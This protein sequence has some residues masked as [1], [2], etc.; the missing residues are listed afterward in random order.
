MNR[1]DRLMA[2]VVHLQ[3]RRVVRAE[4]L[5]KHFE[6]SL[7]TVYRDL[8]A[9]GEA[10]IPIV[11]EPGVG[12]SLINGYHL[13]PV[14]FTAEEA[15]ALTLS[16]K[17][18]E[19]HTD[20]SWSRQMGS[21]LAK[22]RSI[23]PRERQDYLDRLDRSTMVFARGASTNPELAMETLI[24]IQR[25]IAERRVLAIDYKGKQRTEITRREVEPLGLVHYADTWHLIAHCRLRNDLREFRTDRI[26]KLEL[27]TERFF[28]HEDF[29]LK[30]HV[31]SCRE[32]HFE[33]ACVQFQPTAMER[34]RREWFCGA[35]EEE[36]GAHGIVVNLATCTSDW[37]A[38]WILSFGLDALVLSPDHLRDRV[39]EL[40][41][42][43]A[44]QY[45]SG[46]PQL[47]PPAL[48]VIATR[49]TRAPVAT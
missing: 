42:R 21:A 16:G 10:G 46:R 41:A 18:V 3:G 38:G 32:G 14:M 23:L 44:S 31:E 43:V 49:P 2:M 20:A 30:R 17:V 36:V 40:A 19:Q 15:S 25:G 34:V 27:R 5:A 22:I 24:P 11:A 12:Y 26:L 39:A 13:P 4:E 35:F 8:A 47:R 6:L 45:R 1:V 7:R 28:G 48:P 33:M 37:L 29:S 9:L